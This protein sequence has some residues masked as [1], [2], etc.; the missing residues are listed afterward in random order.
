MI[1]V[2]LGLFIGSSEANDALLR[3]ILQRLNSLEARVR[4][5]ENGSGGQ[6]STGPR[7]RDGAGQTINKTKSFRPSST[8]ATDRRK[9]AEAMEKLKQFQKTQKARQKYLDELLKEE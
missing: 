7:V 4:Q 5:L 9:A 2:V 6:T 1:F 3:Q 8:S